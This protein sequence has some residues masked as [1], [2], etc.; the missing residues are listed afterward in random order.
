MKTM[1]YYGILKCK[2]I[3]QP[4]NEVLFC[5]LFC[6]DLQEKRKGMVN[7]NV[8]GSPFLNTGKG[9]K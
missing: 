9:W 2:H 8:S 4:T 5:V 7:T 3:N 6:S 1:E